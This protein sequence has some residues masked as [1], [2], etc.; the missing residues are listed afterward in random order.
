M[1]EWAG[2]LYHG[3]GVERDVTAALTWYERSVAAGEIRAMFDLASIYHLGKDVPRDYAKAAPLYRCAAQ[4]GYPLAMLP[5]A[6]LYC[7]G[8]GVPRD[9]NWA[10]FWLI[11]AKTSGAVVPT[12]VERALMRGMRTPWQRMAPHV[13]MGLGAL[14][15]I[16]GLLRLRNIRRRLQAER[17]GR[18]ESVLALGERMSATS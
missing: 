3:W 1:A 11:R 18:A 8:R 10:K 16:I 2:S 12:G 4:E 13:A 6:E 15:G 17:K 9:V 5:L 7:T 14:A